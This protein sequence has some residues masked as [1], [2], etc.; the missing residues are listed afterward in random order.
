M[1]MYFI[2]GKITLVTPNGCQNEHNTANLAA[3]RQY[4]ITIKCISY[5]PFALRQVLG[6]FDFLDFGI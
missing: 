3:T 2:V 1:Y 6:E 5:L 4:C